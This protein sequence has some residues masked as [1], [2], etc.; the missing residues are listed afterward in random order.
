M[1]KTKENKS[2]E[3]KEVAAV[4]EEVRE[5]QASTETVVD[6]K[7]SKVYCGPSVKGVARQYTVY[8]GGLPEAVNDFIA[9]HPLAAQLIVPVSRFADMRTKLETKG[10]KEMLIYNTLR[11]EL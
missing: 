6:D 5:E 10:S 9:K 3:T 8:S 2:L 11:S 4:T 7:E 1:S